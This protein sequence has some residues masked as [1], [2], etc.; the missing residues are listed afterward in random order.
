MSNSEILRIY[1]SENRQ[2]EYTRIHTSPSGKYQLTIE[3]YSTGLR[4]WNYSRGIIKRLSDN[5][6]YNIDRNYG[7]FPFL[8]F[9]QRG[10]EWLLCGRKYLSQSFFNLDQWKEYEKIDY[11]T[12]DLCWADYDISPDE[13]TMVVTG[14]IWGGEYE[15]RFYDISDIEGKGW[16]ELV[17]DDFL[18]MDD[19]LEPIS[20]GWNKD[21]TYTWR[22]RK[23]WSLRFNKWFEDLRD[24][25]QD[26]MIELWEDEIED[27]TFKYKILRPEDGKM[28]IVE[29]WKKSD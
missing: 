15:Y 18:Y 20:K 22:W 28:I 1:K 12:S 13:N 23:E 5:K 7:T 10:V 6:I 4:T 2:D 8:F 9:T 26:Q 3:V 25:E 11:Q 21:N 27:I 17:C 29:K 16:P 19:V 24:Y 14:C